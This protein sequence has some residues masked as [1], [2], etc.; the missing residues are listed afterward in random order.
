MK[1]VF[2]RLL[3]LVTAQFLALSFI[4]VSASENA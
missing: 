3:C 2:K 4:S 1:K